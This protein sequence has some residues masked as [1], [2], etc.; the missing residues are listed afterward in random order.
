MSD[1]HAFELSIIF[2]S[3]C[4]GFYPEFGLH[5]ELAVALY[6]STSITA[7]TGGEEGGKGGREGGRERIRC[8]T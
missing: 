5:F 6:D 4:V 7:I 1:N 8:L 2:L 3:S